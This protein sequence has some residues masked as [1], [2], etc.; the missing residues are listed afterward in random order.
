M[1]VTRIRYEDR[2]ICIL[3]TLS[4]SWD[5]SDRDHGI[6]QHIARDH[7]PHAHT[8]DVTTEYDQSDSSTSASTHSPSHCNASLSAASHHNH[9]RHTRAVAKAS[10]ADGV[11]RHK[12]KSFARSQVF[13][14]LG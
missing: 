9:D 11:H 2:L 6:P 12:L 4:A 13:N 5:E 1:S 8:L 3:P 14:T 10:G 7:D